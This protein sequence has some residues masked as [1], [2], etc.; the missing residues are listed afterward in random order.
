MHALVKECSELLQQIQAYY[1]K[2]LQLGDQMSDAE[3]EALQDILDERF[4]IVQR[5]GPMML[6]VK[7]LQ[8]EMLQSAVPAQEAGFM[9]EQ[10]ARIKDYAPRFQEQQRR[11][12][13]RLKQRMGQVRQS[14]VGHNQHVQAIR[15]Y[16][17]APQ[18][19]P[20]I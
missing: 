6:R 3:A 11:V 16:L 20:F 7:Q 5:T 14:M 2:A 4:R 17:A 10:S 13:L 1:Q 19:K 9:R 15:Q 18:A 8:Q 12:S